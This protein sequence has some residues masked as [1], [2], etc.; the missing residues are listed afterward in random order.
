[1]RVGPLSVRLESDTEEAEET[2]LVFE[3]D[4]LLYH[5]A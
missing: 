5:P 3:A 1:M 2:G 4:R